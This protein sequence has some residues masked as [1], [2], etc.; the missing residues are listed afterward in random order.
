MN[1][2]SNDHV[3]LG[4][5]TSASSPDEFNKDVSSLRRSSLRQ[6]L[7]RAAEKAT[8]ASS[9]GTTFDIQDA[10]LIEESV[11]GSRCIKKATSSSPTLSGQARPERAASSGKKTNTAGSTKIASPRSP[12][13][14]RKWSFRS[15]T[16]SKQR[17]RY[18]DDDYGT[19]SKDDLG[20]E[21]DQDDSHAGRI[22]FP[23]RLFDMLA[24]IEARG[25]TSTVSWLSHGR[26][27]R[28]HD[29]DAFV[30]QILLHYFRQSK[31]TSFQRQL[32]VYG[33]RRIVFGRDAGAYHH[34]FFLR[35]VRHLAFQIT[36]VG[37]KN[38]GVRSTYLFEEEEPDFY[39]MPPI[40][41]SDLATPSASKHEGGPS[42]VVAVSPSESPLMDVA[43]PP[44]YSS[45]DKPLLERLVDMQLD[46]GEDGNT[47]EDFDL[48]EQRLL[49]KHHPV[50]DGCTC[51]SLPS[52][53]ADGVRKPGRCCGC[54]LAHSEGDRI[55]F[56]GESF[57]YMDSILRNSD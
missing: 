18:T 16:T 27:I 35:G 36:R 48:M 34:K 47:K 2:Q 9:T 31:I 55:F 43:P 13:M 20:D 7:H 41:I 39:S 54:Q 30:T 38:T 37:I 6:S 46:V 25:Q 57:Y 52:N 21:A 23:V 3:I 50:A 22:A 40:D 42:Q 11:K 10:V 24:D 26:A 53:N 15:S 49:E 56:E 32:N 33:F 14:Y 28:V 19:C 5:R 44:L 17:K 51:C 4:T 45:S 8:S 12:T 1:L 29:P